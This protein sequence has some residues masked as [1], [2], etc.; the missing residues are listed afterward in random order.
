[1]R[2]G[3]DITRCGGC[4]Y[5]LQGTEPTRSRCC[6]E[7]GTALTLGAMARAREASFFRALWWRL[8][9]GLFAGLVVAAIIL[10]A[11]AQHAM[12][13]APLLILV[14][15]PIIPSLAAMECARR[16][17]DEGSKTP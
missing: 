15:T 2:A 10:A 16:I 13:V 12:Y 6:P 1:M 5:S 17:P 11:F 3:D 7:C 9:F 4:N 14:I 8:G